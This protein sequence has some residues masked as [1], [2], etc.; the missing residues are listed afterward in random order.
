[1]QELFQYPSYLI[2]TKPFVLFGGIYQVYDGFGDLVF[3]CRR[4]VFKLKKTLHLY[5]GDGGPEILTIHARRIAEL[6]SAYDVFETPT[7]AHVGTLKRN[8]IRSIMRDEWEIMNAE[9]A[10][11]GELREDSTQWAL[12]RRYLLNL[13]P[14]VFY[15]TVAG[16][17]VAEYRQN[18]NPFLLK[19]KVD[20][21][22]DIRNVYDRRLGLAAGLLLAAVERRQR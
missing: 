4:E 16:G 9:E 15:A 22:P 10:H 3:T 21:S 8:Y 6:V 14:Q 1:M 17:I 13:V 12:V 11:I 18:F 7:Q 5:A 19:I 20:F 2:R